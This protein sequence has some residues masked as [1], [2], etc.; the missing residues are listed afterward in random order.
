MSRL[1][2]VDL[3]SVNAMLQEMG[4]RAE[5]AARPSAQAAAQVLYEGVQ[6]NVK[7]LGQHSGNLARSIYQVYSHEN[8]GEGR[9]T[10][11]ISW[12]HRKAPHGALVEFGHI[13]RYVSFIGSD[14]LWYT[15]IRPGMRGK[16]R[17]KRS[18]SQ[19][20]KDAYFVTL[21]TPKQVSAKAFVRSAMANSEDAIAAAK[22]ELL[23]RI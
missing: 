11:H 17:P 3:S 8:S 7:R 23:K 1:V 21:P 16:P 20:A 4:D 22:E 5:S 12:N 14:G 15:A 10:Y 6:A 9:A 2:R 18:A 19:A 13:Q